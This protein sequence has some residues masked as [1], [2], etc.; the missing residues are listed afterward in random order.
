MT[1]HRRHVIVRVLV[2]GVAILAMPERAFAQGD[3]IELQSRAIQKA[4]HVRRD[5]S[6]DRRHAL[7][8]AGSVAGR[9]GAC[10][11]ATASWRRVATG[12]RWR[13]A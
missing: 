7:A 9:S 5:L 10:P 3:P 11:R 6:Q 8:A 1:R 12:R 2:A 4:R 13:S